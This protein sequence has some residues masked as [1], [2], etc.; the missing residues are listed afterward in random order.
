MRRVDDM[1]YYLYLSTAKVDMLFAQLSNPAKTKKSFE[2]KASVAVGSASLRR[3]IDE[4][5]PGQYD[6]L[7][8]I[9]DEI[10][11]SGQLGTIDEPGTYFK[12]TLNM[13]W[14]LFGDAGRPNEEPPLVYFGGQTEDTIFGLGGSTRHVIGFEGAT[15]TSSRSATP[16]IVAH[17]LDGLEIE[18]AGWHAYSGVQHALEGMTVATYKL[19]G[20]EQNLEFVARTLLEGKSRSAIF[21]DDKEMH[22]VL[23]TPL[24]VALLPPFPTGL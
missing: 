19:H 7:A 12:G 17:L 16:Y 10:E 24:Y 13:K 20:P 23:G 8:A 5:P 14:G 21:T 1:K 2:L 15:S 3:E 6:K 18:Q 9:L 4:A 11:S 22:C